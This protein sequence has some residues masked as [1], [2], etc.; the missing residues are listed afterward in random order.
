MAGLYGHSF[1]LWPCLKHVEV[2]GPGIESAAPQGNY[3]RNAAFFFFLNNNWT[4]VLPPVNLTHSIMREPSDLVDRNMNT[5]HVLVLE[6]EL[7]GGVSRVSSASS[8]SLW[9][10]S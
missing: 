3:P 1:F 4:K 10:S 9:C 5:F 2:A 7:G 6:Q 8:I